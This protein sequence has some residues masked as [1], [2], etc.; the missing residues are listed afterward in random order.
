MLKYYSH[1]IRMLVIL[2]MVLCALNISFTQI[3][4]NLFSKIERFINNQLSKQFD[5]ERSIYLLGGICTI[6]FIMNRNNWLP[7]L[8]PSV[9][10]DILVPLKKIEGN[11]QVV[12]NVSPNTKVAYWS[13]K[14]TEKQLPKV[15]EAYDDYS[16]SGVIMSDEN[17]K[18][19]LVFNKGSGYFVPGGKFIEKHVHYRELS[20]DLAM[21]GPVQTIYL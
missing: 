15:S 13:A 17:G 5:L 8:G 20:D 16:N 18:A 19:I 12:I 6:I 7:F 9:L 4:I 2:I 10:P 14:P 1:K 3:N 11:T 21:M